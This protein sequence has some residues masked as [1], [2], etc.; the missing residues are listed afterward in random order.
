MDEG[1][2]KNEIDEPEGSGVM[3]LVTGLRATRH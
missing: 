2:G 1:P 3:R